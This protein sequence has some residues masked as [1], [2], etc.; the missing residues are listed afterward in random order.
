MCWRRFYDNKGLRPTVVYN[1]YWKFV[2][3]QQNI[4]FKHMQ[5][6]NYLWTADKIMANYEF[7]NAYRASDRVSQ[8]LIKSVIYADDKFTPEDICFRVLFFSLLIR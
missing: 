5:K 6:Q 7:T 4:F 8:F 3:E 1:T 2:A